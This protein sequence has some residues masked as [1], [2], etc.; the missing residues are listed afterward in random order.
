[1]KHLYEEVIYEKNSI[2]IG[3]STAEYLTYIATIG[4][5]KTSIEVRLWRCKYLVNTEYV[6]TFY[7]VENNTI[8][9]HIKKYI[10]IMN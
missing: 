5:S 1:M 4:N 3:S 6:V 10:R 9:Y 8:N 7:N 2:T